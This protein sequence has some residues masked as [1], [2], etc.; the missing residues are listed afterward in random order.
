MQG[1]PYDYNHGH[2]ILFNDCV[3]DGEAAPLVKYL[4][5]KHRDLILI[6]RTHVNMLGVMDVLVIPELGDKDETPFTAH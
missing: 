1:S 3:R 6:P 5:Y 4:Q 2:I